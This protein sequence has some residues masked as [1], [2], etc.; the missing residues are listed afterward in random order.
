MGD[1]QWQQMDHSAVALSLFISPGVVQVI[2]HSHSNI[3]HI[4]KHS[5]DVE[6]EDKFLHQNIIFL[7]YLTLF[8][9]L[10][11]ATAGLK[12]YQEKKYEF[13]S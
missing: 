6:W 12:Q 8:S 7:V 4:S 2:Y 9:S 1:G 11:L 13:Q 5:L 3:I 10:N